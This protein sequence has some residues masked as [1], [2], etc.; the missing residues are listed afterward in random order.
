MRDA[1]PMRVVITGATGLVGR[2]LVRRLAAPIVLTRSPERAAS[3]LPGV[4]ARRWD[5]EAE[6]APGEALAGADVVFHLAGEPIA[7]GRWTAERRRRIR[8][9]RVIGTRRLVEG[10][11]ALDR[12][13][14]VLVSA[15]A[16]GYYGDRGDEVLDERAAPG[17]G[18]LAE[19]CAEWEAAA[20]AA[21]EL[22]IR[23]VCAR[24]GMVLAPGG[25]ALAAMLTP[26]RLGLG[27]RLGGGR[28]WMSWVHVDDVA[29]LWLH[30]AR[31]ESLRGPMNAVGPAPVTNAD[32]TRALAGAL[33]RP[34]L[35][36]VP[37]LA[38]RT[39]FGD[40]AEVLTASQRVLPVVAQ[41][42]GYSF[43]HPTLSGALAA[44]LGKGAVAASSKE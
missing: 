5:P 8:D 16:V 44:A 41:G 13:P 42:S 12:R 24:I 20:A 34:A 9:S 17:D 21:V 7:A 15:S 18:F 6:P 3:S 29:G 32:F 14:A 36:P 26:F 19:I 23:V 37:S 25:G 35:L 10:L 4:V 43:E 2:A 33:H 30:A 11:G 39:A 31:T 28:Q 40:L 27:G 38:L 1:D 22:G